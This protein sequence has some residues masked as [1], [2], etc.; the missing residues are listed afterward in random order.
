MKLTDCSEANSGYWLFMITGVQ[1]EDNAHN[2]EGGG[3]EGPKSES[4]LI[5]PG[6][7][8]SLFVRVVDLEMLIRASFWLRYYIST[9]HNSLLTKTAA[10]A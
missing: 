4:R 5:K 2:G 9:S 3:D 8:T 10:S 1:D 7:K 6:A